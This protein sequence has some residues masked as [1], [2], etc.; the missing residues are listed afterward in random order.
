MREVL[1]VMLR[2]ARRALPLALLLTI[3]VLAVQLPS[4]LAEQKETATVFVQVTHQQDTYILSFNSDFPN[5]N[6]IASSKNFPANIRANTMWVSSDGRWLFATGIPNG[7]NYFPLAY[8][9]V[10]QSF[11]K[12]QLYDYQAVLSADDRFLFYNSIELCRGCVKRMISSIWKAV[13]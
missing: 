7:H 10:G 8:T 4:L 5:P 2:F 12:P 3:F 13:G 9:R 6:V 11:T 1:L